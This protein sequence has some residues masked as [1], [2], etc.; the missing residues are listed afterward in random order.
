MAAAE[1][2]QLARER[3]GRAVFIACDDPKAIREAGVEFLRLRSIWKAPAPEIQHA[4]VS[5]AEARLEEGREPYLVGRWC[6]PE[7]W[8]TPWAK[9]P[10]DLFF[11]QSVFQLVPTRITGIPI[12]ESVPT[13]PFNWVRGDIV[14]LVPKSGGRP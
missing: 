12:T 5:W 1:I 13:N 11:L 4:I 14:R 3:E 9:E 10:F 2:R 8:R 6:L 7:E